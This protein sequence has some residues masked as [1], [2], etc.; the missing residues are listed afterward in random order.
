MFT[1]Y[2]LWGCAL[3]K[4]KDEVYYTAKDGPITPTSAP[5][6]TTTPAT[7]SEATRTAERAG[8]ASTTAAADDGAGAPVGA[9]VG[10]VVGGLAVIGLIG[11]GAFVIVRSGKNKANPKPQPNAFAPGPGQSPPQGPPPGSSYGPNQAQMDYKPSFAGFPPADPRDST[12]KPPMSF[13]HGSMPGS[14]APTYHSVHTPPPPAGYGHQSPSLN[15]AYPASPHDYHAAQQQQHFHNGAPQ[16]YPF[17]SPQQGYQTPGY[18]QGPPGSSHGQ[19][20]NS[21][22]F[23]AELPAT[24]DDGQ[25]REL[26][27]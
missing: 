5:V 21:Y 4:G 8:A 2:T 12:S 11:L 10:G 24:K 18:Q 14:P 9:I 15:P 23:A 6:E 3:S 17:P 16:G 1:G 20:P 13:D 25:V 22:A 26:A 19:P 27:G 7:T